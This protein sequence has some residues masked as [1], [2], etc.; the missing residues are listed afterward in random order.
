MRPT[1][2]R[3]AF[4]E[5]VYCGGL[6]EPLQRP[7][8]LAAPLLLRRPTGWAPCGGRGGR[9]GGATVPPGRWHVQVVRLHPDQSA[10]S[11]PSV[12]RD[13]RWLRSSVSAAPTDCV[14]PSSTR[15]SSAR[16]PISSS[17]FSASRSA[18]HGTGTR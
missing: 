9:N 13:S 16:Q 17:A 1:I 7:C 2:S 11:K 5:R 4:M 6:W 14:R 3:A 8:L 12:T 15:A 18:T 10:R